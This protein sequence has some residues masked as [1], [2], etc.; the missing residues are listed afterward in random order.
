[1]SE[2][3]S[4]VRVLVTG[5]SQGIGVGLARSFAEL[6][7]R[8]VIAGRTVERLEA[9]RVRL[10]LEGLTVGT[11]V[12]DVSRQAGCHAM[13]AASVEVLGGLDVLCANAGV[14]PEQRIEDLTEPDVDAVLDTNLKGTLFS[15]QAALPALTDSGRGRV[16]VTTSIT[17]PTTGY[18]GLS[19]YGASKAAQ[20]GFIRTAALEIAGRGI[21]V[22]GVSPGAIRTEGLDGLGADAIAAMTKVIPAGRLGDPADIGAAAV[23]LAS[24]AA[25]FVTGQEL[26]VDGGQT[27]PEFPD[28]L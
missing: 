24:R 7:A 4:D 23:F 11:V 25:G 22:N 5:G 2:S 10:E 3:W 27:L 16:V 18:P 19:V 8:V 17:G 28:L 12:A 26:V 15:V 14:Y 6:G 21:T 9:A 13:V 1:M 20:L